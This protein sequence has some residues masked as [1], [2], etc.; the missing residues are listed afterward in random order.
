MEGSSNVISNLLWRRGRGGEGT[1]NF[2]NRWSSGP[3]LNL[4]ISNRRQDS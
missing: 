4:H 3:D 1:K 2:Q